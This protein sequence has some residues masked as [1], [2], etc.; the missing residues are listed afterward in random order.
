[1]RRL[2]LVSGANRGLGFEIARQLAHTGMAVLLTARDP[3][4]GRQAADTLRSEGLS[5]SFH[6][7]DVNDPG[8]VAALRRQV[9]S[10]PGQLDVLVNNAGIFVDKDARGAEVSLDTVR[11]TLETN[12]LGALGLSQAFIPLMRRRGYGRIVN[13]S[14]G[15][16]TV[17]EMEG[18]YPSYRLSKAAL[19]AMTRILAAEL[20]DTGILVN[21]MCPGWCRTDMG[22]PEAH[23]SAA[24]GADTAVYLATLP[25]DGPTGGYFR[26]RK[27][28]AW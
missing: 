25:D 22:G 15:L 13:L 16:G 4:R 24:E 19:N 10:D 6:P 7:L 8:S 20:K 11:R 17:S 1:M 12:L 21:A 27:P 26:D 5:V 14:S 18:G 9:E 23:R 2:A 3:E 28:I